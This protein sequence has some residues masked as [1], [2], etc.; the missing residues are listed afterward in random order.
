M[1]LST[2][3]PWETVKLTA[4]SKDRHLFPQLL[5]EA[6]ELATRGQA[7]KVVVYTAWGVE[8]KPFGLPRPKRE[9]KSVVLGEGIG[10]RIEADLRAFLGRG[11]WYAERGT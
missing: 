9:V 10:E 3:T 2:G 7:G 1:D 4:L 6:R 11:K 8:W 5:A